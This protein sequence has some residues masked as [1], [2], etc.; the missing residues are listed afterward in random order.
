[1]STAF[2]VRAIEQ[3]MVTNCLTKILGPK[4]LGP[5]TGNMTHNMLYSRLYVGYNHLTV[6]IPT[7][8]LVLHLF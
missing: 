3:L 6:D 4:D 2:R 1:M 8:S 5:G 7:L